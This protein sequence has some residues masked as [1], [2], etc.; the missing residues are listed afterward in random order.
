M[1]STC[2]TYFLCWQALQLIVGFFS[3][4]FRQWHTNY[5]KKSFCPWVWK[6]HVLSWQKISHKYYL[7]D[8]SS[9]CECTSIAVVAIVFNVS[10]AKKT[11][12]MIDWYICDEREKKNAA[13]F[14]E[15]WMH[16]S[17]Q[18][19]LNGFP[20]TL[21]NTRVNIAINRQITLQF[22]HVKLKLQ[23]QEHDIF[24]AYDS[25]VIYCV[26]LLYCGFLIYCTP[27]SV[28]YSKQQMDT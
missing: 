1:Q 20:T 21:H 3:S 2:K 9:A 25:P 23:T 4:L 22:S 7:I 11:G 13:D 24:S 26:W 17:A 27:Y 8:V 15:I 5:R 10:I 16:Q 12:E 14:T 18:S 19:P 6:R 28:R